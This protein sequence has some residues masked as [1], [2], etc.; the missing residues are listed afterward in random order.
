MDRERLLYGGSYTVNIAYDNPVTPTGNDEFQ[1]INVTL[2]VNADFDPLDATFVANGGSDDNLVTG[3]D[4][5]APKASILQGMAKAFASSQNHVIVANGTYGRLDLTAATFGLTTTS[6]PLTIT[7]GYDPTT[8]RR[9]T[10]SN[11][12][13]ISGCQHGLLLDGAKVTARQTFRQF[14]ITSNTTGLTAADSTYGVRVIN[15]GKIA[16]TADQITAGLAHLPSRDR[17]RG[18][19]HG[20]GGGPRRRQRRRRR[21]RTATTG[22][23]AARRLRRTRA[24]TPVAAAGPVASTPTASGAAPAVAPVVAVAPGAPG[25]ATGL[26]AGAG[27]PNPV[28]VAAPGAAGRRALPARPARPA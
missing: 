7:G 5:S 15:G 1:P 2:N 24:A 20:R 27:T 8:W 9:S 26:S 11:R 23:R 22:R 19:R 25:A 4:P 3:L 10:T 6:A 21:A 17:R 18:E 13:T 28:A 16:F 14:T 12:P